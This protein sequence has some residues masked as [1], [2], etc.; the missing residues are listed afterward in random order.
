MYD[1]QVANYEGTFLP[2]SPRGTTICVD[3]NIINDLELEGDEMFLFILSS[4]TADINRDVTFVTITDDEFPFRKKDHTFYAYKL[5][6][7]QH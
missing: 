6:H 2:G 7:F 5:Y 3:I 1:Y 4:S